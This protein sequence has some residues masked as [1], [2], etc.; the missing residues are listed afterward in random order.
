MVSKFQLRSDCGSVRRKFSPPEELG[1]RGNKYI[2]LL[3]EILAGSKNSRNGGEAGEFLG[4]CG[5]IDVN[6]MRGHVTKPPDPLFRGKY[7]VFFQ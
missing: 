3:N 7:Y 1:H 5:Q 2:L 6:P 4:L